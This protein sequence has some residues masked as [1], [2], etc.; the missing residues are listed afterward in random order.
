MISTGGYSGSL[1][2]ISESVDLHLGGG[3][4][5]HHRGPGSVRTVMTPVLSEL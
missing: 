2:G 4:E 5:G 1:T 3:A